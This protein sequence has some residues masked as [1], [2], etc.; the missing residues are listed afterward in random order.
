MSTALRI[1]NINKTQQHPFHVL[2][3]SKLPMFMSL[4]AG[5]T[6]LLFVAKLHATTTVGTLNSALVSQLVAPFF[7][8]ANL[9]YV[10]TD[11]LVL[12]GLVCAVLVMAS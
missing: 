6:A 5:C 9:A 2:S 12:F 3:S 11:M 1:V 7:E 10:S 4:F 8:V